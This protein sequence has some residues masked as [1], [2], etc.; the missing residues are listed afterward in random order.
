MISD[1]GRRRRYRA[2]IFQLLGQPMIGS[3]LLTGLEMLDFG[4]MVT[5]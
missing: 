3:R 5:V 2:H 1:K 4:G